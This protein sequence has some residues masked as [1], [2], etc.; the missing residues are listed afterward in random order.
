MNQSGYTV[1]EASLDDTA[2]TSALFGV[3]DAAYPAALAPRFDWLYRRNPAG[4]ARVWLL[5]TPTGE[6]VGGLSVFPRRFWAGGRHLSGAIVG[7]MIVLP[8][9]RTLGPALMLQRAVQA[10]LEA[11]EM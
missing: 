4:P 10:R 1:R 3:W 2:D 9:H 5:C 7:D 8:A 6:A 11:G